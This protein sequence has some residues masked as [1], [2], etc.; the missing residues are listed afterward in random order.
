MQKEHKKTILVSLGNINVVK[1]NALL[2]GSILDMLA[3]ASRKSSASVVVLFKT[4]SFPALKEKIEKEYGDVC[5]VENYEG[6]PSKNI[7]QRMAHFFYSYLI[8]SGTT[9]LVSSYNVRSDKAR[10]LLSYWN[11]P[12]KLFIYKVFG[13]SLWIKETVA[14]RLYFSAF[15]NRPFKGLFEKYKPDVVFL[16]NPFAWPFDLGILAEAKRVGAKTVGMPGNWDHLSKYYIPFKVDKL[17]V[18]SQLIKD[19][20]MFYQNYRDDSVK[21]VGS[22]GIDFYLRPENIKE[23]GQFLRECGFP[24]ESKVVSYFSQG[25]YTPDGADYVDMII[26]SVE[27]CFID[28]NTRIVVRPHPQGLWEAEKYAHFVNNPMIHIDRTDGWSTAEN[29]RSYMNLLRHSD[30]VVTTYSTVAV[31]ANFFDRPTIIA[32]FDGY[33]NRPMYQS[34]KRHKML[35][36]FQYLIPIGGIKVAE[37]QGEFLKFLQ[38]YMKDPAQDSEG[39]SKLRQKVFG[40]LDGKNCERVVGEIMKMI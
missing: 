11:Q 30:V 19:E 15:T 28:K 24:P 33:K 5:V 2:P 23:R 13:G 1:N 16:T 20:A 21:I 9:K 31:E 29:V 3:L 36:H 32:G 34:L 7:L 10:P 18:W 8:F 40:F 4:R 37:S 25:P 12:L 17:L 14:P 22:P 39:R 35:T 26:K 6:H 38:S 27:N